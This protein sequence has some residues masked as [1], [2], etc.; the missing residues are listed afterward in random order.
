LWN[1]HPHYYLDR[2]SLWKLARARVDPVVEPQNPPDSVDRRTDGAQIEHSYRQLPISLIVNLA[3]GLIL[4]V[5][6]WEAADTTVLLIWAFALTA[7]T[8]VRF[9]T[10]HAIRNAARGVQFRHDIWRHYFVI[11][12][13][14]A[15]MVWGAAGLLLFHP[16]SFPHQVFLAF[17]LG[18]MVA[19]AVPLLSSVERAYPCFAIPIVVP[20]SIRMLASGDHI[21]L[22]MG[23]LILIFGGA[24]LATSAQ[25]RRL[26]RDTENLRQEL[27]RSVEAGHA[28]QRM[29]RM[30]TL[31][32]IA[33]RRLF[34]EEIKKEWR[35]AER[36]NDTLSVILADIDHFKEYNDH[37]GHLAGDR[38][39]IRVA[40]TMASALSRPGDVVA[41]VGGEE[42]AFL[43]PRTNRVGAKAVAELVRKR[44]LDLNIPH[45]ASPA[46]S[47]I[48]VSFGIAT[49]GPAS[50]ST[51]AG[52]LWA[53]DIALY[54]AKRRG[55]NQVAVIDGSVCGTLKS[56]QEAHR[57][58]ARSAEEQ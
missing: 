23:L 11:G 46:A 28:L 32:E 2:Q 31:T 13:C 53:S 30:D 41:R 42:F 38:C 56:V 6:L 18:G 35:R 9:L 49:S 44:I 40:Q 15:G 26:F 14:A 51:P 27:H 19:G 12:A 25:V 8:G 21:H 47:Q 29:A 57:S 4:T 1:I 5:V 45:Q 16:D 24:M 36:D 54:E 33:N 17:V 50:A 37:Y 39:L 10:L 3:N 48:T 55:R 20:I 34:E 52:L 58:S 7:V 43:L 22:I